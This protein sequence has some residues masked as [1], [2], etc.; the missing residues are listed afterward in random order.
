MT[1]APQS[2]TALEW[3]S[4][5]RVN[6]FIVA[7]DVAGSFNCGLFR[8]RQTSGAYPDPPCE[9]VTVQLIVGGAA[10]GRVDL[11]GGPFDFVGA[12]GAWGVTAHNETTDYNFETPPQGISIVLLTIPRRHVEDMMEDATG[13]RVA[14][15]PGLHSALQRDASVTMLVER[16]FHAP[17]KDRT[18]LYVDGIIQALIGRLACLE[19]HVASAG[20]SSVEAASQLVEIIEDR[21]AENLSTVELAEAIDARPGQVHKTLKAATGL[22]PY[23]YILSRRVARAQDMLAHRKES[24]AEIAYACGFSSQQHMTNVFTKKLGTTPGRYRR[25]MRS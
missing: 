7:Q 2:V 16:L 24:L 11:G 14:H 3:F 25:D 15:F 9:D 13:R 10:R 23:Q 8:T 20:T 4:D 17:P 6:P 19:G 1:S 21:L 18:P 22:A 12:S 5:A